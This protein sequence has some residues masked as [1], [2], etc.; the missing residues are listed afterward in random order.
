MCRE[1]SSRDC[2]IR[3]IET[4]GGRRRRFHFRNLTDRFPVRAVSDRRTALDRCASTA[5]QVSSG[6]VDL[7]WPG[8][9]H[10][11]SAFGLF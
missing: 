2:T 8:D 5:A 4:S 6:A 9:G 11:R 3:L 7:G 10:R 1:R